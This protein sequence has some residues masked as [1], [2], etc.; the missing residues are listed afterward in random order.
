MDHLWAAGLDNEHDPGVLVLDLDREMSAHEWL[1]RLPNFRRSWI[2]GTDRTFW[3]ECNAYGC[4]YY[5]LEVDSQQG[6]PKKGGLK[7][8]PNKMQHGEAAAKSLI[9]R[10]YAR[11]DMRACFQP[12]V[13]SLEV[14][15]LRFGP[16]IQGFED[17]LRSVVWL[18]RIG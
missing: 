3:H 13:D 15:R 1:L 14:I 9:Y 8:F 16:I 10:S 4:E 7:P 11:R 2:L 6:L 18:R 5:G 17:S 12:D